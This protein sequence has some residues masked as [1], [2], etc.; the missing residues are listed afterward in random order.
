[1]YYEKSPSKKDFE[2]GFR[3]ISMELE[4]IG[5]SRGTTPQNINIIFDKAMLKMSKDILK[6][7]GI[8][9]KK[10]NIDLRR[11]SKSLSFQKSLFE[12][13]QMKHYGDKK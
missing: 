12:L 10:S 13:I 2:N 6:F 7:Y 8:D 3:D 4:K 1:M 5:N 9:Y 11:I